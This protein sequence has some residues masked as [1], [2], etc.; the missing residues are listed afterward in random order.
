MKPESYA[1][2]NVSAL[3]DQAFNLQLQF[4]DLKAQV[5]AVSD[6]LDTVYHGFE[7]I[8]TLLIC[9]NV[10]IHDCRP[11]LAALNVSFSALVDKL[12]MLVDDDCGQRPLDAGDARDLPPDAISAR[13]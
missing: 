11:L 12:H 4:S 3:V 8:N 9:S 5:L 13:H 7:L 6:Q 1:D 10:S 2:Q